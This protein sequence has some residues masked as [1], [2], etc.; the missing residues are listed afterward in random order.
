MAIVRPPTSP[1]PPPPPPGIA[2]PRLR[3]CALPRPRAQCA[4]P[5]TSNI[6]PHPHVTNKTHNT[7]STTDTVRC[8]AVPAP[9][10]PPPPMG[11]VEF[12]S[13]VATTTTGVPPPHRHVANGGSGR[14]DV[15]VTF[16]D[17]QQ[18]TLALPRMR[19]CA[20]PKV[21]IDVTGTAPTTITSTTAPLSKSLNPF[22]SRVYHYNTRRRHP[23]PTPAAAAAVG[24][25]GGS[26]LVRRSG[27]IG[28][29]GSRHRF[30]AAPSLPPLPSL[31]NRSTRHR[32][33]PLPA[34]PHRATPAAA[35]HVA[36]PPTRKARQSP[37]ELR[38]LAIRRLREIDAEQEANG[39]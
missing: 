8:C 4:F 25:V 14:R 26:N 10:L 39:K 38:M 19:A 21:T 9:T 36:P 29:G 6:H 18:R 31:P 23:M 32:F 3:S 34:A 15:N 24:G 13:L 28:S 5:T 12:P 7:V 37:E 17:G 30:A 2:L 16:T 11:A 33:P 20:P 1:L 27:G 35:R 22:A